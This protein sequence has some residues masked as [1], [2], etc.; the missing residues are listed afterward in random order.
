MEK[1]NKI[2]IL[3]I[4]VLTAMLGV[5]AGYSYFSAPSINQTPV[6]INQ[7]L[8]NV[9]NI[10]WTP[11][12]I[13]FDQAKNIAV[14]NAESGVK[15]SDP[16]LMKNQ[17]GVAIYVCYY[18]YNGYMIGG[19]IIDARTG[20]II[21]KEQNKPKTNEN[22]QSNN[23]NNNNNQ[24]N[25]NDYSNDNYNYDDNQ[26]I[27]PTCAGAGVV[28]VA[29][30]DPDTSW[31]ACPTC[32]GSGYVDG[33]SWKTFLP[34]IILFLFFWSQK[35][36]IFT[37]RPLAPLRWRHRRSPLPGGCWWRCRRSQPATYGDFQMNKLS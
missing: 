34:L 32:G 6:T 12:F 33:G 17:E 14:K 22:S 13:S 23:N 26:E 24:N 31:E 15:V 2:L 20:N 19:I 21:Y 3:V 30:D 25:Q 8:E 36:V 29:P 37:Y 5:F 4:V 9:T 10:T 28:P 35:K 18:Y 16:V 1:L 11:E 7:S 27:C